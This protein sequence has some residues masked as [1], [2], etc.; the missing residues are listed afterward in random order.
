MWRA[1]FE[2]IRHAYASGIGKYHSDRH[3][4]ATRAALPLLLGLG[5][6]GRLPVLDEGPVG[7]LSTGRAAG[8]H[9]ASGRSQQHSLLS[10]GAS[11]TMAP[12]KALFPNARC[13][14]LRPLAAV[15][16]GAALLLPGSCSKE[17][18]TQRPPMLARAASWGNLDAVDSLLEVGYEVDSP[19]DSA[20]TALMLAARTASDA[21]VA[22]LVAADAN[23]N[24]LDSKGRSPLIYAVAAREEPQRVLETLSILLEAGADPN[25]H[26]ESCTPPLA[27]SA[28]LDDGY[29]E[30]A[31]LLV[32]HGARLD[33]R[34]HMGKTALMHAAQQNKPILAQLLLTMG[35]DVH[36]RDF[37]GANAVK[38]ATRNPDVLR[39]LFRA[40]AKPR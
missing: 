30:A 8:I 1:V 33:A 22:R 13:S 39:I 6:R 5:L 36:A 26:G 12:N 16:V 28:Y 2:D 31:K 17:C 40:G 38:H 27:S 21:V 19:D 32:D 11:H 18:E 24:A 15:S 25:H 3:T 37:S 29:L 4:D 35:A 14:K 9:A 20:A 7:S 34:D 23:V 10:S